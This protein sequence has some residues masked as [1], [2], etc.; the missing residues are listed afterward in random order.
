MVTCRQ[1]GFPGEGKY[2]LYIRVNYYTIIIL[3]LIVTDL[4]ST[5][6]MYVGA[7]AV[8]DNQFGDS[9]ISLSTFTH[10]Q[11][12]GGEEHL[13]ECPFRLFDNSQCS[14]AGVICEGK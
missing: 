10:V 7:I 8:I 11:C 12:K 14:P 4:L 5:F 9:N 1:M 13:L 2:I 6:Y 3:I